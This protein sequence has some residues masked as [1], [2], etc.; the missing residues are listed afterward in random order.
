MTYLYTEPAI[1]KRI[2]QELQSIQGSMHFNFILRWVFYI[3][4]VH[5]IIDNM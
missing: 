2:D 4:N 5:V 3:T 1:I